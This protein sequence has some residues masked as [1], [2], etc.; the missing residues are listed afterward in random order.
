[1]SFSV[2]E[3]E[4]EQ[5]SGGDQRSGREAHLSQQPLWFRL[6]IDDVPYDV[7]GTYLCEPSSPRTHFAAKCLMRWIEV[8]LLPTM[9][10][11]EHRKS[12]RR[13]ARLNSPIVDG[14]SPDF[15]VLLLRPFRHGPI[16]IKV[17]LVSERKKVS[18]LRRRTASLGRITSANGN[19]PSMTMGT[20]GASLLPNGVS[21]QPETCTLFKPPK[22]QMLNGNA[23]R[24]RRAS[25]PPSIHEA[26]GPHVAHQP[27]SQP[28]HLEALDEP[29]E[30]KSSACGV[31][32]V[33]QV[34]PH[35]E[36]KHC[37]IEE[38]PP[39]VVGVE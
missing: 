25:A 8:A 29:A 20:K 33:P 17:E 5:Q 15:N 18:W 19:K 34:A 22:F 14:L 37:P 11:I 6:S 28:P 27:A 3:L 24:K 31:N 38:I 1:M 16:E 35:E 39:T 2:Y 4:E 7:Q 12:R 26:L 23:T 30:R 13:V 36:P 21:L 32:P 9:F 10:P